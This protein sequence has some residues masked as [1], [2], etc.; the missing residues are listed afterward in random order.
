MKPL[1]V[2]TAFALLGA[3]TSA[4]AQVEPV[5][6]AGDARPLPPENGAALPPSPIP[7]AA[8]AVITLRD[9]QRL[10]GALIAQ[11][12]AGA[13]LDLEGGARML[14]PT[15]SVARIELAPVASTVRRPPDPSRT[16]YLYSPSAFMLGRGEGS[17]SQT[18]LVL[19]SVAFGLTDHLTVG[20]G[21]SLPLLLASDGEGLNFTGTVKAGGSVSEHLH[22]A[23]TAQGLLLPGSAVSV[24][25]LFGTATFGTP[26][27]HVSVSAG[28]PF[29][30]DG[31]DGDL[32]GILYSVSGAVRVSDGISLVTENWIVP[33]GEEAFNV[34]SGALRFLGQRLA[35]DAGLVFFEG[36]PLALPWIDFTWRFGGR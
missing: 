24:G 3:S 1:L 11:D 9:G 6:V 16:R 14:V 20:V 28:S 13:T 29:A 31:A 10:R 26:D 27:A 2:A 4:T 19:T 17:V 7:P 15:A 23:V 25:I 21:T 5:T 35:V 30:A 8:P 12:E 34:I 22:L 18:E 32:G 36:S 33:G